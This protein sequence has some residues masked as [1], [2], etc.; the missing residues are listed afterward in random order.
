M[1]LAEFEMSFIDA[2]QTVCGFLIIAMDKFCI[3]HFVNDNYFIFIFVYL[4]LVYFVNKF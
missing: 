3:R 4:L 1:S 2:L